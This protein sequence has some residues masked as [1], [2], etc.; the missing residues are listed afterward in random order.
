MEMD[1]WRW[2]DGDV[3]GWRV[4][5]ELFPRR[6]SEVVCAGLEGIVFLSFSFS[7]SRYYCQSMYCN[8]EQNPSKTPKVK[9]KKVRC[10]PRETVVDHA[11]IR[12][13]A[14]QLDLFHRSCVRGVGV[15][16]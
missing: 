4:P 3:A 13:L 7:F 8:L 11:R 10:E 15:G 1:G 14:S 9:M 6:M 16:V 2:M 12:E 5:D